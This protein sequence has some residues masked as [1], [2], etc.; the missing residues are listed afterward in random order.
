MRRKSFFLGLG[1]VVLLSGSVGSVLAFLVRHKPQVYR[2]YQPPE[3]PERKERSDEFL[4]ESVHLTEDILNKRHWQARF[5]A[6]QINSYLQEGFLQSGMGEKSLPEGISEPRVAIEKEK[7]RLA[8]RYGNESW[9]TVISI[10]LRVWLAPRESNVV[11]LELQAL[12]AG[13]LPISAQSLLDRVAE[14]ARQHNM[15]LTWY[16]H[17][18]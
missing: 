5:T 3:G 14:A 17:K 15:E 6:E 10:D 2:Q 1:I 8:F 9:S 4:A 12:R 18:G 16:R 13:S 11:V 7:I